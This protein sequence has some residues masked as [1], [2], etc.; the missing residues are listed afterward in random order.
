LAAPQKE[1]RRLRAAPAAVGAAGYCARRR[2]LG[3]D[4]LRPSSCSA[5]SRN[6]AANSSNAFLA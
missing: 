4:R 1:D 2:C 6:S 5:I 3:A